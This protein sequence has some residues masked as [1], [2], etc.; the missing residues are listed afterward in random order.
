[1]SAFNIKDVKKTRG[2]TLIELMIVVAIIGILASIALPAYQDYTIRAQ[3]A[4]GITMTNALKPKVA[5]FYQYK[6]RFPKDNAE[7]G[8]PEAKYM[9]GNYVKSMYVEDGA[10]HVVLGNK[11]NSRLEGK[12][13]TLRPQ[14]VKESHLT[15]L[16]WLCGGSDPV[17]GMTVSGE[18]KTDIKAAYLPAACR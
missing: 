1:M 5:E 10:I 2:F 14:Y 6:G 17:D 7:A 3:M 16:A 18:N 11:I 12:T 8:I 15:P 4:E 13:L 9:M